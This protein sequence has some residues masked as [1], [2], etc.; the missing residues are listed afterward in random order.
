MKSEIIAEVARVMHNV[1]RFRS[2]SSADLAKLNYNATKN[3]DEAS[4]EIIYEDH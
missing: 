4:L 2:E 1:R 3:I